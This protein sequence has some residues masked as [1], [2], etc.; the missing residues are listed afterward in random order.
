MSAGAWWAWPAALALYLVFRL[1]Y[2]NWRGPLKPAEVEA[3]MAEAAEV[4]KAPAG[5]HTDRAVLRAFL[6]ADD[7]REFIMSN[8]VGLHPQAVP[9]PE[10]GVAT[11]ALALMNRYA[12][13]FLPALLRH[14]GHPMMALRK[15]GGYVDSWNT[16]PD[17]GWH[18]V[19]AM[20]YRSRRDMMKL[21]FD[22]GLRQAHP[23]KTAAMAT[24]FSFPTQVVVAFA[25]GPRL[26]VALVLALAA[27]L[28]HL[29]SLIALLGR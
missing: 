29:A 24:T 1:W 20:R 22:P 5:G 2:D 9:H 28:T 17:P 14:G 19:G 4:A 13:G 10:T 27:A 18:I 8:L 23:F 7:G 11:P 26:W 25:L 16:P 15:V 3:F 12:S 6:E 21:A